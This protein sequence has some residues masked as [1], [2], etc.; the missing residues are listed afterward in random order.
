[1]ELRE[2]RFDAALLLPNSFRRGCSPGAAGIP[3]RWGYRTDCRGP[4]LTR[5]VPPPPDVHQADYYQHLVRA[6]G[7]PNGPLEPTARCATAEVRADRSATARAGGM[8]R[9]VAAGRAGAW[10]GVR[11]REALAGGVVRGARDRPGGRRRASP[12]SS[13]APPTGRWRPRLIA[14]LA[15]GVRLPQ[16]DRRTDLPALAGVLCIAARS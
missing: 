1:M 3:E 8:G 2:R 12:S 5:A 11:R 13:G 10:R 9:A 16:P 4:L 15:Q 14:P 7:L 6:L